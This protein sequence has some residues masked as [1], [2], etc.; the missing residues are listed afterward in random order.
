M[1]KFYACRTLTKDSTV[2]NQ[3]QHKYYSYFVEQYYKK[4]AIQRLVRLKKF[5]KFFI[6]VF[7]CF[8]VNINEKL[9]RLRKH[10]KLIITPLNLMH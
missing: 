4:E 6:N 1:N 2:S 5:R 7:N 8:N 10:K 3:F 9:L